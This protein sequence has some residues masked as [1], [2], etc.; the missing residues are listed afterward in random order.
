MDALLFIPFVAK[1]ASP[2]LTQLGMLPSS[3]HGQGYCPDAT[4]LPSIVRNSLLLPYIARAAP[5]L[6]YGKM[7]LPSFPTQIGM[8]LSPRHS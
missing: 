5:L 1:D 7:V 6:P 8:S 4:L 2:L 3:L